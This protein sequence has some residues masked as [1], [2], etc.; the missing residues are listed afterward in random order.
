MLFLPT[1]DYERDWQM[2]LFNVWDW[3]L[4]IDFVCGLLSLAALAEDEGRALSEVLTEELTAE[5]KLRP[6]P[7]AIRPIP[8]IVSQPA[9]ESFDDLDWSGEH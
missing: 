7:M 3:S 1:R 6:L 4:W 8:A 9:P 5:M 2:H